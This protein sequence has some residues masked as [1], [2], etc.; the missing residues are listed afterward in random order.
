MGLTATGE[1]GATVGIDLRPGALTLSRNGKDFTAYH[2]L[3][4][5]RL[6][7]RETGPRVWRSRR[8]LED[9][10]PRRD[11]RQR[12]SPWL[13]YCIKLAPGLT[14]EQLAA[15]LAAAVGPVPVQAT[16]G[17]QAEELIEALDAERGETD[18]DAL[19]YCNNAALGFAVDHDSR[20]HP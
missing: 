6:C 10:G 7:P 15:R 12:A 18:S 3:G 16:T 8:D 17:P 19:R 13:G 20:P 4:A 11:L 1:L 14:G 5:I 9:R 2:A